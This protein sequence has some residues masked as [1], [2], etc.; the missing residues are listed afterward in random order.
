L[1]KPILILCLVV[2][3]TNF[4]YAQ[5][6]VDQIPQVKRYKES[7]ILDS[8][9][10]INM[11]TKLILALG[12]DS[13]TYNKFGYNLQGWNEY[14]YT[15]GKLLHRGYYVDGKVITFKNYFEN[16]QCERLFLNPDPLHC[17]IDIFFNNGNTRK[18]VNYYNG[19]PQ[20]SYEYYDNGQPKYTEENEKEMTYLTIKKSWYPN[21]NV[22]SSLN[23]IDIKNKKYT[24]KNYYTNGQVKEEGFI[25]FVQATREYLKE[26]IWYSYDSDGKNKRT[27]RYNNGVMTNSK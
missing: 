27:E 12:G 17:T 20:K 10:G 7:D 4:I 24:Q 16:G 2:A 11:Y 14:F 26:G 9:T 25:V 3:F 6:F 13:I 23:L 18:K 1:I 19:Q 21:G 8:V 22:E 5:R 15:N